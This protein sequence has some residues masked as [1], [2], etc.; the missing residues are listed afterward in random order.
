MIVAAGMSQW[1]IANHGRN[2]QWG[3]FV[4]HSRKAWSERDVGCMS[5][6]QMVIIHKLQKLTPYAVVNGTLQRK[7]TVHMAC[8]GVI[9]IHQRSVPGTLAAISTLV[10]I[11]TIMDQQEHV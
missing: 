2:L 4:H 5:N 1:Y 7:I 11:I 3:V 8:G 6:P 9:L 10:I